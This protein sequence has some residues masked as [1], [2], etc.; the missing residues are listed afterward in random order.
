[1]DDFPLVQHLE[2]HLFGPEGAKNIHLDHEHHDHPAFCVYFLLIGYKQYR[3]CDAILAGSDYF[4]V[5]NEL[6]VRVGVHLP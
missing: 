3:I 2:Y 5:G 4:G 6:L 1:M